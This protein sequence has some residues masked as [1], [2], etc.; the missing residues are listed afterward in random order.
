MRHIETIF[1]P[2]SPQRAIRFSWYNACFSF[3]VVEAHMEGTSAK[4]LVHH[5]LSGYQCP[6]CG[7]WR[8]WDEFC[9]ESQAAS[10]LDPQHYVELFW[11]EA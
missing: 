2:A 11:D 3:R 8:R 6:V 10:G 1:A 9:C 5:A 7:G 4:P